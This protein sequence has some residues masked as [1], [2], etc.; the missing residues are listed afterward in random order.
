MPGRGSPPLR[1]VPPLLFCGDCAWCIRHSQL[2]SYFLTFTLV[3]SS[4]KLHFDLFW[5]NVLVLK[6]GNVLV[7]KKDNVLALKKDNVLVLKKSNVLV[8]KKDNVLVLKKDNVLVLRKDS[9]L[10]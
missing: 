4:N 7:L 10:V 9:V 8:L 2:E 3:N 1:E 5:H 6:K